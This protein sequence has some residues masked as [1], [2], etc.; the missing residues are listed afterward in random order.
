MDTFILCDRGC[1]KRANSEFMLIPVQLREWALL[2]FFF[3]LL[4]SLCGLLEYCVSFS[5]FHLAH[6]RK[7]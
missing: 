4:Y 6:V 7:Y 3:P 5:Q 2:P 1:R